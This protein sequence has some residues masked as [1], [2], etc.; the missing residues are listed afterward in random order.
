MW[1][2][3]KDSTCQILNKYNE[4]ESIRNIKNENQENPKLFLVKYVC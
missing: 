2:W 4:K 3:L 1:D